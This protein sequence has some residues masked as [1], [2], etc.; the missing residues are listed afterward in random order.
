MVGAVVLRCRLMVLYEAP[1]SQHQDQ[2]GAKH[3]SG[4]QRT[5]LGDPAEF[6]LLTVGENKGIAGHVSL[7]V[8]QNSNVY[9][10]TVH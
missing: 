4:R 7:N 1:L 10:A 3:I 2:P 8:S 5:R 6:K 9:S